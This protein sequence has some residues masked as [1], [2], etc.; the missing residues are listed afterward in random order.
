[1]AKE[2]IKKA[3]KQEIE[4]KEPKTKKIEKAEEVVTEA[5]PEE[6]MSEKELLKQAEEHE[7]AR[8]AKEEEIKAV[9]KAEIREHKEEEKKEKEVVEEKKR[10][11][12]ARKSKA[13]RKALELIDNNESYDVAEAIKLAK[14]TKVT[15]FDSTI[16]VHVRIDKKI[17]NTRGTITLPGGAVKEKKVLGVDEKNVEDVVTEVKAGKIDF[18]ILVATP[19]AMPKL[20]Q[21]AKVLGPKGLMPNP[22]AGTVAEDLKEAMEDFKGGKVEYKADKGNIVHLAI[23]KVSTDD[24]KIKENYDALLAAMPQSKIV[25]VYLTTTMGPSVRVKVK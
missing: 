13:Y 9:I 14:E 21:L 15:K 3:K 6:E 23:G 5:K 12:L 16:E 17:Q 11:R 4:K 20:A 10:S 1:M 7:K 8:K 22:K 2:E 19:S 24:V 25:S 18:D